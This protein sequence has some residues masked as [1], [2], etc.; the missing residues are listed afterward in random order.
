M[1]LL[2]VGGT[3]L[4]LMIE[5]WTAPG[6]STE[7]PWSLWRDGGQL[8]YGRHHGSAEAAE[9]EGI[10]FCRRTL[11]QEPDRITRL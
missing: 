8:H 4:E 11:H 2:K 10:E 6:G 5:R 3:M 7:Y 1:R 9:A